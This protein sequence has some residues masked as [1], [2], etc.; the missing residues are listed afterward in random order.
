MPKRIVTFAMLRHQ[1]GVRQ[2]RPFREGRL[3]KARV[4]GAK[5]CW[6]VSCVVHV[7]TI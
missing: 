3:W 7:K 6:A 1:H 5:G 2:V 4:T